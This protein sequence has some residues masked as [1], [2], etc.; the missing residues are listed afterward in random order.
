M[1]M[2]KLPF[3]ISIIPVL[4]TFQSCKSNIKN[5][6]L[7]DSYTTVKRSSDRPNVIVEKVDADFITEATQCS[8]AGIEL[9]KL[10]WQNGNSKRVKRFGMLMM[11]G[12]AKVNNKIKGMALTKNA[13]LPATPATGKHNEIAVLSKK[14]GNEFDKAYISN[15]IA[16][17][18]K[19][20]PVFETAAKNCVDPEVKS[21]AAKTLP[22]LQAHL[23][24]VNALHDSMQ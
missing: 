20:I 24:A 3:L 22:M 19:E 16:D 21:L 18:K 13:P 7:V 2:N 14:T 5:D 23:D 10:A 9:G 15:M 6:S 8:L 4:L 17:Y 1:I 12:Y 11:S